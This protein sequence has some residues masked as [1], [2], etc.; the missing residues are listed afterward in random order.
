MVDDLADKRIA[1]LGKNQQLEGL[2]HQEQE[3]DGEEGSKEEEM[4]GA[5]RKSD[6][7]EDIM[8]LNEEIEEMDKCAREQRKN[9]QKLS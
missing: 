2:H 6:L 4:G 5:N 7:V 1:L 9:I 3:E 8:F